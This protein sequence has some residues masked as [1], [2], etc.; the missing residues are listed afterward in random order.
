MN[1]F[2]KLVQKNIKFLYKRFQFLR[3]FY[4]GVLSTLFDWLIFFILT[5]LISISPTYAILISYCS[6]AIINYNLNKKITFYSKTKRISNQFIVFTI[7]ALVSM[8]ISYIL[9]FIFYNIFGIEKM[10]SRISITF[11]VFIINYIAH[12]FITFNKKY[13]S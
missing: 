2:S 3:F 10:I 13:F 8:F 4:V 7:I 1:Q 6:G 12:K 11:I 5:Y 9:L